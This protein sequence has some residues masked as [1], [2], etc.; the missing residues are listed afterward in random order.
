MTKGHK[1]GYK[2]GYGK[3]PRQSRFKPGQS[4]NPRGGHK[5]SKSLATVLNKALNE[6]VNIV[7]NGR[8]RTIT[9][10]EATI[11]QIVNK[12]AAGDHRANQQVIAM[13]QVLENRGDATSE[14]TAQFN[15]TDRQVIAR[16]YERAMRHDHEGKD[17]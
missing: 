11:K 2:V 7:E 8:R 6:H 9:K 10:F 16:I 14:P 3:P 13:V 12:A 1:D 5:G 15:D 4:G 17:G